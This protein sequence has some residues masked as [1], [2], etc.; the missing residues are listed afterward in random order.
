[1]VCAAAPIPLTSGPQ[2][3]S[4]LNVPARGHLQPLC[5][6]S[7]SRSAARPAQQL[8][9]PDPRLLPAAGGPTSISVPW[10]ASL[11]RGAIPQPLILPLPHQGGQGP[12]SPDSNPLP[13]SSLVELQCC[14]HWGQPEG[15]SRTPALATAPP[16]RAVSPRV[17]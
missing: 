11:D 15:G 13:E 2:P 14:R 16:S 7:G 10:P 9:L 5:S 8:P 12:P 6:D 3:R 4:S 17:A 1:M